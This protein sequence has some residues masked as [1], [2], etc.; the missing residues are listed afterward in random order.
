LLCHARMTGV[1]RTIIWATA[2]MLV[3]A[4][5]ASAQIYM[6]RD[7]AG[8]IVLSD[9]PLESDVVTFAVQRSGYRTTRSTTTGAHDAVSLYDELIERHAADHGVR[10]ELVRAVIQVES[11]FNAR[12]RSVKGAMGLMQ[13]MPAT[14]HELGVGNPWDPSENIRGGVAYLAGLLRRFNDERLALAA[15]NAGPGAVERY[16]LEV[17][18]YRE[19]Q[20]YVRKIAARTDVVA[21]TRAGRR[22]I[23]KVWEVV[24]GRE[25][26]RLTDVRP[27]SGTYEVLPR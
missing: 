12:A 21:D 4:V 10:P 16:G 27:P 15:Y 5:D 9:R 25:V 14:A 24:D 6:G 11:G 18:P 3:V 2:A 7:A 26:M 8:T 20:E 19:T 22:V 1:V 13:L 23:Y 17:P